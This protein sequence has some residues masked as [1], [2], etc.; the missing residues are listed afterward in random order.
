[1][2]RLLVIILLCST[3]VFA[4][5]K[6]E[7]KPEN[8]KRTELQQEWNAIKKQADDLKIQIY[9]AQQFLKQAEVLMDGYSK[10][11]M[12][13]QQKYTAIVQEEQIPKAEK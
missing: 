9:D 7:K 5:K 10:K 13:I 3:L 8:P 4:Q 1:M 2:Y 11:L 12:E 6:E